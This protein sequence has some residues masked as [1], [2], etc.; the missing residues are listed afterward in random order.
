MFNKL[1]FSLYCQHLD[2]I[3]SFMSLQPQACQYYTVNEKNN[4]V[5]Y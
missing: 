5:S 1:Q 2:Y 3:Q 4:V